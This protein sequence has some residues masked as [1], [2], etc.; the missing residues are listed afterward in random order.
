MFTAIRRASSRV[1]ALVSHVAF[2]DL[3]FFRQTTA[4]RLPGS[5]LILARN[6]GDVSWIQSLSYSCLVSASLSD[7]ASASGSLVS[8]A[9]TM[10]M[11]A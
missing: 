5:S 11:A 6:N 2:V 8:A 4:A 1:A 9:V 7:M 10:V 3:S